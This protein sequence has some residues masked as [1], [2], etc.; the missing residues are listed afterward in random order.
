MSICNICGSSFCDSGEG[1]NMRC[2]SCRENPEFIEGV[3]KLIEDINYVQEKYKLDF[4]QALDI[5]KL[6]YIKDN[7]ETISYNIS[8]INE[9]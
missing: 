5:V 2:E 1:L 4:N 9:M 3:R 7:L 8:C 6:H